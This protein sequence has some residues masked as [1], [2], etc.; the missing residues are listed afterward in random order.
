[1]DS[2]NRNKFYVPKLESVS[3]KLEHNLKR[4]EPL[5]LSENELK[6]GDMCLLASPLS[7]KIKI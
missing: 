7:L 1:M 2:E 4:S 6:N 3:L 5:P